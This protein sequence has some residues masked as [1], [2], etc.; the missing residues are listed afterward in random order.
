[1]MSECYISCRVNAN[2]EGVTQ[3]L[4]GP[5]LTL[6]IKNTLTTSDR[7]CLRFLAGES[8]EY[9]HTGCLDEQLFHPK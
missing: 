6:G 9:K 1:M 8:S 2:N 5:S 4:S 7:S 3:S